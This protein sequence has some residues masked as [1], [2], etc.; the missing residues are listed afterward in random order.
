ML[1]RLIINLD[2]KAPLKSDNTARGGR[3]HAEKN[4]DKSKL[5]MACRSHV[6]NTTCHITSSFSSHVPRALPRATCHIGVKRLYGDSKISSEAK[7]E[8]KGN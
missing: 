8:M 4:K 2:L 5:G 1:T 3:S 7:V 6:T